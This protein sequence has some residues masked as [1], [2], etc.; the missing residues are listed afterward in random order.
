MSPLQKRL[1]RFVAGKYKPQME[2]GFAGFEFRLKMWNA[3]ML[4][5]MRHMPPLMCISVHECKRYLSENQSVFLSP[6]LWI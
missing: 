4:Q 6:D 5:L 1:L 2:I 3:Y